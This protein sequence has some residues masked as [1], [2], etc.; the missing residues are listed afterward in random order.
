MKM[1][2]ID[3]LK[4]KSIELRKNKSGLASFSSFVLSE[5]SNIGKNDGNRVTTDNEAITAIKKM[6][7][8]NKSNIAIAKDEYVIL[9]ISA[10]NNWLQSFLP[11]MATEDQVRSHIF[12]L[13]E[14]E[15]LDI[16]NK[17][18]VMKAVKAEFGPLV[19]MKMVSEML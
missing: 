7:E 14:K 17:G 1:T 11:E 3:D 2:L 19:D 16:S 6:I 18:A 13:E 9:K 10:E 4:T 12:M 15:G 8:R 5:I